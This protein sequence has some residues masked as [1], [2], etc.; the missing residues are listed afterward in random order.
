MKKQKKNVM[1]QLTKSV[2]KKYTH[3]KVLDKDVIVNSANT[4]VK[5][6]FNKVGNRQSKKFTVENR[7]RVSRGVYGARRSFKKKIRRKTILTLGSQRTSNNL[8]F[9]QRRL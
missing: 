9:K 8:T 4:K 2:K 5:K 1:N 3:H 7:I 6:M